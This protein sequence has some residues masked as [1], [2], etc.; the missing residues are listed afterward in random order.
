M[1]QQSKLYYEKYKNYFEEKY[2]SFYFPLKEDTDLSVN[3]L[4]PLLFNKLYSEYPSQMD[5]PWMYNEKLINFLQSNGKCIYRKYY[6]EFIQYIFLYDESIF[7]LTKN[8]N[9]TKIK[10][11]EFFKNNS[12]PHK[13]EE[14]IHALNNNSTIGILKK[15]SFGEIE[16]DNIELILKTDLDPKNHYNDD[17]DYFK[18]KF[19]EKLNKKESGLYLLHGLPGT[20][21][22]EFCKHLLTLVDRQ[23]IFIPPSLVGCLS[24]PEFNDLLTNVHNGSVI[25]IEDAEKALMKRTQE[26]GFHNSD[27]VSTILNLTDGIFGDLAN[28]SIIATYN[29]DRNLIDEALL[30]KG[31]L[32]IEYEF[33]KLSVEKSQ[34]LMDKLGFDVKVEQE[35]TLSD[36]FNYEDTETNKSKEENKKIGFF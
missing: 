2:E 12:C 13:F 7:I 1:D 10:V 30:R 25:V 15:N 26:D 18:Q 9:Q 21:K 31:R 16:V 33:K 14:Y 20:G 32:K 19:I 34:K 28:I 27:L 3:Q 23:F 6:F 22:S 35:M 29:C 8:I 11:T 4:A 17:F 24:T 5:I 36:I